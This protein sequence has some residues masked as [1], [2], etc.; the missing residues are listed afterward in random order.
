MLN[1][2]SKCLL[3]ATSLSPILGAMA[4]NQFERGKPWTSWIWWLVTAVILAFL[5]WALLRSAAKNAQKHLVYVKEFERR[6]QEMLTF[7]FIYLLPFVRSEQSTFANEW[8]TSAY[9]LAIIILAIAHAGAFHF[10]PVMR[11]LFG[12]RFYAT[13]DRHG[14]SSLLISKR[15]LRRPDKEVQTVRL[16]RDVYLDIGESNA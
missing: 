11:L 3:V 8:L 5:C 1:I 12:Y 2:A 7:L 15:D 13:K 10:N 14:V 4:I 16:A 9:I 6:D